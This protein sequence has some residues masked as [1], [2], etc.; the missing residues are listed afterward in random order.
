MNFATLLQDA[1]VVVGALWSVASVVATIAPK[2][3]KVQALAASV[4][5]D[6]DKLKLNL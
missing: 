5:L 3:S 2:G 4:A 1:L 6:L